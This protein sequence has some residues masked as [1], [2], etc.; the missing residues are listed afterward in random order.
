MSQYDIYLYGMILKTNSFLLCNAYPKADTYGEIKVKYEVTGGETATCATVLENLGCR[1]KMDGNH[2]GRN[3]YPVIEHF[4]KDK[5]VDYSALHY[6]KEYEGLEDYVM[7]DQETRTCFGTFGSYF[8]EQNKRWNRPNKEDILGAKVVGLD[9][10]FGEESIQVAKWCKELGKPYVVIDCPFDSVLNQFASVN[11]ISN[12]YIKGQYADDSREELFKKYTEQT[13][14]LVILTLGVK[15]I[16]YGRKGEK[17]HYFKPYNVEVVS[18]LGAGDTFKAGCVYALFKE[19]DD[20]EVVS[21][22]SACAGVACTK[23]P[24]PLNPPC[25]EEIDALQRN[26]IL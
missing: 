5:K 23:F 8:G 26:R 11:V 15:E 6:D 13:E 14:G 18:T 7:I 16:M 12:E 3:T 24:I 4:Y 21:F 9:P 22:A 2:M 1:I 25:L 10:F 19:M 20:E 17:P